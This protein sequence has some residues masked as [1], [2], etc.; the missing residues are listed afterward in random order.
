MGWFTPDPSPLARSLDQFR[1]LWPGLFFGQRERGAVLAHSQAAQWLDR[2]GLIGR[3]LGQ[4]DAV[5]ASCLFRHTLKFL[6]DSCLLTIPLCLTGSLGRRVRTHRPGLLLIG[7]SG[8]SVSWCR[9]PGEESPFLV[10]SGALSPV[11]GFGPTPA[12]P[13]KPRSAS[14]PTCR[15][16]YPAT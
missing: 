4:R 5:G 14:S 3:S 15:G 7:T 12:R 8:S 16:F 1:M 2:F 6:W 11:R 10:R 13:W 9:Q